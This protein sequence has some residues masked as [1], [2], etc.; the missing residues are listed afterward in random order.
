M[1]KILELKKSALKEIA[2]AKDLE[3][4]ENLRRKYLSK[5]S[6]DLTKII[7]ELPRLE[8]EKRKEI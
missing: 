1:E 8:P 2:A 6:G 4:L 3:T 7:K 5:K